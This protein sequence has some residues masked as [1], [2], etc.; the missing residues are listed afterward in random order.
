VVLLRLSRTSPGCRAGRAYWQLCF[1]LLV[2]AVSGTADA[3]TT[4]SRRQGKGSGVCATWCPLRSIIHALPNQACDCCRHVL[5]VPS[6]CMV[7]TPCLC[8]C[9]TKLNWMPVSDHRGAADSG[10]FV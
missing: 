3:T 7:S 5:P 4:E 10:L 8:M 1:S 6:W 9:V 2:P